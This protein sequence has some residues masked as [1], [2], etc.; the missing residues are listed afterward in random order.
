MQTY[1]AFYH[2]AEHG[3]L[4][5]FSFVLPRQ[6]TNT[7]TGQGPNDDHPCHDVALGELLLK[8]TYEAVRS[9]AGWNKT[10][11]FLIYDD[12]G[13]FYGEGEK[14]GQKR[15]LRFAMGANSQPFPPLSALLV[16]H[17]PLVT[18]GV[19]APDDEPSCPSTTDYTYLGPRVPALMVQMQGL[20][21]LVFVKISLT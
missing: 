15:H 16:D 2:A 3:T 14:A 7:T 21:R 19:P 18:T 11:M 9:G 17:S 20:Y 13:G 6:G 1:D 12:A 5:N 10:V 8:D 4:P